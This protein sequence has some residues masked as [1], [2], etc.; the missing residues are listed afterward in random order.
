MEKETKNFSQKLGRSIKETSLSASVWFPTGNLLL[1]LD[2]AE[3]SGIALAAGTTALT[4][5]T[6]AISSWREKASSVSFNVLASANAYLCGSVLY[7]GFTENGADKMVTF[8][9]EAAQNSWF[10]AFAFGGWSVCHFI[11]GYLDKKRGSQNYTVNDSDKETLSL[12]KYENSRDVISSMSGAAAVRASFPEVLVFAVGGVRSLFNKAST[13]LTPKNWREYFNK[14]MTTPRLFSAT[15]I[16][17]ASSGIASGDSSTALAAM[18]AWAA[19][20]VLMEPEKN[21]TVLSDIKSLRKEKTAANAT[22]SPD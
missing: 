13:T 7:N 11:N 18:F 6:K 1:A 12:E 9:N 19:G 14:H 16:V 20:Q 21:S 2:Q 4:T 15:Y 17:T 5:I 8:A 22:V 10:A 3:P